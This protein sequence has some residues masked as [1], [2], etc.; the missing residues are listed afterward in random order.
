MSRFRMRLVVVAIT[1]TALAVPG[2]FTAGG[3]VA[4]AAPIPGGAITAVCAGTPNGSTYTL[5]ADCGD[6][7]SPLTVPIGITTVDGG[8][9]VISATDLVNPA[10]PTDHTIPQFNGGIV[11]N[12]PG[13]P[14]NIQ[15]V[16]ITGPAAGFSLCNNSGNVLYGIYFN[17]AAGGS[18]SNVTV[19]HIFQFQNGAFGSCQTGRAIRADNSGTITITGTTVTDYQKS[20]FEARGSTI[21]NVSLSTA[22]PPHPLEGLIAQNA[23]SIVNASG[24]IA[25]NT[26]HGSG[27]QRPGVGGGANGTAVLLFGAHDVTVDHNTITGAGTDVGVSVSAGSSTN[28]T[29]SFNQIGRIAPDNP[30]PTGIGIAVDHPTSGATL[31]CNTFSNWNTNI[32]GAV[33]MS[34]TPLPDGTECEPY[35]ANTLSVEGGTAPFTWSVESGT[36]PPGLSLSPADA[37]ITGTPTQVGTFAFTVKVVDSSQPSLTATQEQTITIAPDCGPPVRQ[38][39]SGRKFNDLGGDG[40]NEIGDPGLGGWEIRAY[41]DNE[42]QN[43]VLDVTELTAGPVATTTTSD[44]T[45]GYSFDLAPGSYVICEVLQGNWAQSFPGGAPAECAAGPSLGPQGHAVTLVAGQHSMGNAFGNVQPPA[46]ISICHATGDE[47]NP[48]SPAEPAI[49]PGGALED[50]HRGHPGDIIPPYLYRDFDGSLQLFTG[51]HWGAEGQEIWGSDCVPQPPPPDPNPDPLTPGVECIELLPGGGFLAHFGYTNP[52]GEVTVIPIGDRN[53]F[54]PGDPNRGQPIVFQPGPVTDAVQVDSLGGQALTWSLTGNEA[55]ATLDSERC[56]GSITIIKQV[57]SPLEDDPGR[58]N[59]KIDGVPVGDG[60]VGDGGSAGPIAVTAGTHTVGESGAGTKLSNFVISIVCRM[61]RGAGPVVGGSNVVS[62]PVTVGNGEAVVCTITNERK[63]VPPK[64]E[65]PDELLDLLVTKTASPTT[66]R[67]GELITWTM[68]VTNVSSVDAPDV[69]GLKINE[70][71]FRT[72]LISLT[73]S[74][75]ACT[76]TPPSCDLGFI[77]AGG[78]VTI[79]A[80]TQAT[81]VGDVVNCVRATSEEP[82]SDLVNNDACALARVVGRPPVVDRCRELIVAPKLLRAGRESVVLATARNLLGSPLAG[83]LVRARGA[84][85]RALG[86]TDQRGIARFTFTPSKLGI[87]RFRGIGQRTAVIT[88]NGCRTR[89]G[90]LPFHPPPPLTGRTPP[91]IGRSG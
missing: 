32:A 89:L 15:N 68:T 8:G 22:G 59:L 76:P 11:T 49:L 54:S 82:E 39:V 71:S 18:V 88:H 9:H 5:T 4:N 28:I 24:T 46:S 34:C 10:D 38:T 36:L 72:E 13:Q 73:P 65:P 74:Q 75:G 1:L 7:T 20:G 62:I 41:A 79:T 84:G 47:E 58:F 60:P 77:P 81:D 26:I 61:G 23:V 25:N 90:V 80:V 37:S 31:I 86:R 87:V 44:N 27:D 40:L 55:V 42:P 17:G 45:G 52:N 2:A 50:G 19:D 43:G 85:V 33:Q 29:I 83:I 67:E 3:G 48:Y 53:E 12:T 78:S 14:M 30:D 66:V 57:L 35:S 63:P 70:S 16:T 51:Q 69:Q 6:V 91:L 56:Q 21:M 64:P